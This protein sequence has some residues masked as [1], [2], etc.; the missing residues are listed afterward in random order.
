MT[1]KKKAQSSTARKGTRA[2]TTTTQAAAPTPAESSPPRLSAG[3]RER[4]TTL[5]ESTSTPVNLTEWLKTRAPALVNIIV[6]I[7]ESVQ[8][9]SA[10]TIAAA[11]LELAC[12]LTYAPPDERENINAV[13]ATAAYVDSRPFFEGIDLYQRRRLAFPTEQAADSEQ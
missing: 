5:A 3:E 6:P 10:E 2:T 13:I 7:A 8:M 11:L 9:N 12:V 4:P 1:T